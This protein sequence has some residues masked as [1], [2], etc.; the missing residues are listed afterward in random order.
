MTQ[1]W[2]IIIQ[3]DGSPFCGWQRQNH[4][5]SV[6]EAIEEAIFKFSGERVS[7]Y[8]AGRTDA[9][10][11]ALGQ[12]AHF[13]LEKQTDGKTVAGAINAHLG[14]HPISILAAEAVDQEFHARFSALGRSYVYHLLCRQAR[15]V[16]EKGKVW[17]I[18]HEL[19]VKAMQEGANYLIG[20]HDFSSFRAILCQAKSPIKTI[21]RI[22]FFEEDRGLEGQHIWME[23]EA[24]SFMHHQVRNIIG[25][26][27]MVGEG[28]WEPIKIKQVLEYKDRTKAGPTGSPDGLYFK[29]VIY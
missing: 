1:R 22:E 28:K 7:I 23:I 3:Y 21:D 9:G 25:N 20:K 27:K 29:S 12:V 16:F 11:H 13:D 2:K 5:L 17:H 10:V 6:Q 26:L 14:D 15:P 4:A 18:K 8:A 19:D 24:R